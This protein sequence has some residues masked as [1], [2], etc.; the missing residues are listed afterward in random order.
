MLR[1]EMARTGLS[2]QTFTAGPKW[3][4]SKGPAFLVYYSPAFVRNF[5]P[6]QALESLRVLAEVYRRAR[7]MWPIQKEANSD[8][9]GQS[10]TIRID[11]IKE[12]KLLDIQSAFT[13][14]ESWVLCR[15]NDNEAVVER[16]SL[17]HHAQVREHAQP[18]QHSLTA[19]TIHHSH[20][21]PLTTPL[22]T[23]THRRRRRA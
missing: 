7:Q 1:D 16:H 3:K 11:Q 22:P 12:L 9:T 21:S 14:G 19:P 15:K 23:T 6:Q 5:A 13:Q 17:E 10:V 4:E 8:P 18:L 2:G 20:H